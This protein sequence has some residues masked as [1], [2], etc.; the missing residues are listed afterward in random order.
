LFTFSF[1]VLNGCQL[2]TSQIPQKNKSELDSSKMEYSSVSISKGDAC[3]FK[4]DYD[5]AQSYYFQELADFEA[6]IAKPMKKSRLPVPKT[7]DEAIQQFEAIQGQLPVAE[8]SYCVDRSRRGAA[9]TLRQLALIED[10]KGNFSQGDRLF[11]TAYID[12]LEPV[13]YGASSGTIGPAPPDMRPIYGQI[14]AQVKAKFGTQSPYFATFLEQLATQYP[15]DDHPE[16]TID[17]YKQAIK[18][19]QTVPT[20]HD[21]RILELDQKFLQ[22]EMS[23]LDRIKRKAR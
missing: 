18:I 5:N 7:T 17:L 3:L 21:S 11:K 9:A 23:N 22:Y 12:F 4:G 14:L 2:L 19:R 1:F 15:I 8:I 16:K 13:Y 10:K 20:A 6:D